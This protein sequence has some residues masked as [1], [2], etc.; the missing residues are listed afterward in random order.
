M[1]AG[2]NIMRNWRR[3]MKAAYMDRTMWGGMGQGHVTAIAC[4]NAIRVFQWDSHSSVSFLSS[5]NSLFHSIRIY[6]SF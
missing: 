2:Q 1:K 3:A 4:R 5:D 6:S